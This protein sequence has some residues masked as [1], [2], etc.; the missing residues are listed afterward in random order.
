M[1]YPTKAPRTR[2]PANASA[3]VERVKALTGE[4]ASNPQGAAL[5]IEDAAALGAIPIESRLVGAAPTQAEHNALVRDVRAIAAVLN[6]LGARF[7]GL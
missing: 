1:G 4:Q 3:T 5:T 2:A 7:T 6:R